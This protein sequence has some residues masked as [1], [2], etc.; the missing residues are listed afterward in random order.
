M[1]MYAAT[2]RAQVAVPVDLP[3]GVE[4]DN[5]L[6][7]DSTEQGQTQLSDSFEHRRLASL[8]QGS[9]LAGLRDTTYSVQIRSF[10]ENRDNFNLTDNQAWALGGLAG[11][12]TGYFANF[13]SFGVTGYTSQ[14]LEGPLDKDGTTLLREDQKSYSALGELYG[15]FKITDQI[16]AAAGRRGFDTPFINTQDSFM[17]PNTFE[18]Y[19]IQGAAGSSD[20]ATLRFGVAYVDKIK[21]R[22]SEDFESMATAAGAPAGVVR[23]VDVAGGN[24][25]VGQ[26][27]IGAIDYYSADIINIAYTEIKY[28]FPL[29]SG[30]LV[31]LG[32]Q[33]TSQ[34]STGA[35]LLTGKN[36]ASD[37]YGLKAELAVGAAL[38][39]VARSAT[40]VGTVDSTGS[41]TSLRNPWGSYPGYTAVQVENF[42]RGG[43]N[44]TLLRAAYN[45]PKWTGLSLYGLWV[46]GSTPQVS[47]QYA[48]SEYDANLQW[49]APMPSLK[50]LKLRARYAHIAQQ[51]PG[52]EH[53]DDLR[54]ILYYQYR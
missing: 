52:D 48:Q 28:A 42:Y 44:A 35:P 27:S 24:F 53:E 45:L 23:G 29:G 30:L 5:T 39:T 41:G 3:A 14:R 31:R 49:D 38:F 43:E 22:N 54:L 8:L 47:G 21:P 33:Y 9:S 34:R 26:L 37:Q 15:E 46:H 32:A 1:A 50:G 19:A 2:A 40:S 17:T 16:L 25:K 7:P 51:G 4:N 12:K 36:F 13:V 20:D 11:L 18:M 10:Y 6:A